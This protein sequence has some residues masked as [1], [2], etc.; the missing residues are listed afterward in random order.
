MFCG[1]MKRV[2]LSLLLTL[3]VMTVGGGRSL[4]IPP[5]LASAPLGKPPVIKPN[6]TLVFVVDLLS[7]G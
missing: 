2:A 7:I 5:R 6:E 4:V 1:Q 3:F